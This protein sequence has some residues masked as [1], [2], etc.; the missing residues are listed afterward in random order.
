MSHT[1]PKFGGLQQKRGFVLH[2]S[3]G[4]LGGSFVGLPELTQGVEFSDSGVGVGSTKTLGRL[5]PSFHSHCSGAWAGIP[6]I[7][8]SADQIKTEAA[9]C[10]LK[11]RFCKA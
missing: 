6:V 2:N 3:V 5:C 4:W 1:T 11:P 9:S 7:V 8:A 10:L